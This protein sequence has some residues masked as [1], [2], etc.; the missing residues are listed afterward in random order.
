MKILKIEGNFAENQFANILRLLDVLS[1][2]S[3]T[4]SETMSNY[5]L[6][7]WY[8]RVTSRVAERI[9]T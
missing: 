2:F 4:I 1:N 6:K 3:L 7:A 9:K 8:I 5:S